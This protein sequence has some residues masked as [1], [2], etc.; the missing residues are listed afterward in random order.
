MNAN[1]LIFLR[2]SEEVT[3]YSTA[4]LD[5]TGMV[6]AFRTVIEG[7]L[8]D[9]LTLDFYGLASAVIEPSDPVQREDVMRTKVLPSPVF[10]PVVS[11][12][13]SLWYLGTWATLPD[14]WYA[15]TGLKK[16]VAGEPGFG[17]VVS[18]QSYVEQ[19]SY[20]TAGAHTPGAKPTGYGSW[21]IPPV[22]KI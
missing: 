17:G 18:P 3:G 13:I 12:L 14:S 2:L 11:G 4:D 8:G 1:R 21:S 10:W 15:A 22:F 19:L 9:T 6:D 20:R 16:P 7:A 5:G